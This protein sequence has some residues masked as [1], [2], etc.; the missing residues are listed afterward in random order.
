MELRRTV[1]EVAALVGGRVEGAGD[2]ALAAL[3]GLERAG[4]QDL[5]AVFRADADGKARDSRAGCLLVETDCTLQAGDDRSLIRVERPD[6]A[7]DVIASACAPRTDTGAIGVHALAHVDP[8]AQV[9]PEA[10][11]DPFVHIGPGARVGPGARLGP[12]VCLG[13]GAVVGPESCLAAHVVVGERCSVGARVQIHA[14]TVLGADGFGFR[15]DDDGRQVKIPQ[16]GTVEIHDDVEIGANS[17]VDRA[18]FDATVIGENSKLDSQVHIGHNVV[19]GRDTAVAG[20]TAVAG[21][22]QVGAGVL[23]GGGSGIVDGIRLGDGAIVAA[24]TFVTRDVPA[25]GVVSGVP[26]RPMKDW[27]K[28]TAALRKLPDLLERARALGRGP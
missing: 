7:V 28:E 6:L 10:S 26:A 24:Y 9:H 17:T 23:I 27:R 20:M 3:C 4:P 18:R 1:D 25:G 11:V 19:V 8:A 13:A 15:R 2:R 21:S 5:A 14:G 22:V 12:G 16:L